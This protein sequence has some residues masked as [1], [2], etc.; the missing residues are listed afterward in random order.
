MV[1][2]FDLNEYTRNLKI[3]MVQPVYIFVELTIIP[4]ALRGSK[5]SLKFKLL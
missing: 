2:D 1:I 3:E 4:L 5:S